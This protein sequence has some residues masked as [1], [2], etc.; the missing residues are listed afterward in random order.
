MSRKII[1]LKGAEARKLSRKYKLGN[2]FKYKLKNK[3]Y[4]AIIFETKHEHNKLTSLSLELTNQKYI[5][6]YV[7]VVFNV[8]YPYSNYQEQ[9]TITGILENDYPSNIVVRGKHGC[10][11]K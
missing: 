9:K 11:Y 3:E 5:D 2:T 4:D 7:R 6:H 1:E 10:L 8:K